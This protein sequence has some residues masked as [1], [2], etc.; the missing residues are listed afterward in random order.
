MTADSLAHYLARKTLKKKKTNESRERRPA[1][2]NLERR[3]EMRARTRS[4]SHL[5]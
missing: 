2:I 1:V 4:K 5:K 3:M